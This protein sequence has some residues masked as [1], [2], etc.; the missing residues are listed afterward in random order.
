MRRRVSLYKRDNQ[1]VEVRVCHLRLQLKQFC[2]VAATYLSMHRRPNTKALPSCFDV[3]S[4][5]LLSVVPKSC[6]T[7]Q[8]PLAFKSLLYHCCGSTLTD[9]NAKVSEHPSD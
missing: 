3:G 8:N 9:P 6:I 7:C 1:A 5:L 4:N 2:P